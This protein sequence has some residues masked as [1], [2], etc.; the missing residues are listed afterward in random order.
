MLG[1]G[2]YRN[3]VG[4]GFSCGLLICYVDSQ[5]YIQVVLVYASVI[6]VYGF[7]LVG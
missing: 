4:F 3:C 5:P 6:G 1:L 2:L 7:R